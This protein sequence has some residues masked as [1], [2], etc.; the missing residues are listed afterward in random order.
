MI[1]KGPRLCD[2]GS[3]DVSTITRNGPWSQRVDGA[4]I[5]ITKGTVRLEA[6]AQ[7]IAVA[8]GVDGSELPVLSEDPATFGTYVRMPDAFELL[9]I[10]A[11]ENTLLADVDVS[12][13]HALPEG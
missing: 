7:S 13:F 10:P 3:A 11:P 8:A 9:E 1:S 2:V 12:A 5:L 4:T 6:P